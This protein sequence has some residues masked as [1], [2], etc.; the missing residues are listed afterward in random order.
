MTFKTEVTDLLCQ[1]GTQ[2]IA[3]DHTGGRQGS[4]FGA[5]ERGRLAQRRRSAARL[6]G[7]ARRARSVACGDEHFEGRVSPSF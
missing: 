1:A 7:L 6:P 3:A 5:S 4:V 2:G